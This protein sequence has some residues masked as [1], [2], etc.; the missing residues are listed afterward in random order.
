[1]IALAP[2]D[3]ERL[4]MRLL[5][6]LEGGRTA[7]AR[8]E[9]RELI[10][11]H[12]ILRRRAEDLMFY[13]APVMRLRRADALWAEGRAEE[14]LRACD[15]V[16]NDDPRSAAA[17]T[18]KG[19]CLMSLERIDAA[20]AALK[21]ASR[22]AP[23]TALPHKRLGYVLFSCVGDPAGACAAYERA[24]ALDPTDG[25]ALYG[26]AE[27]RLAQGDRA[28][29]FADLRAAAEDADWHEQAER[30]IRDAGPAA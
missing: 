7:E 26:R 10:R 18:V 13:G 23:R 20:C 24:L 2:A 5:F 28:G 22:L 16:L 14:A 25:E 15:E 12:P 8:S 21:E 27:V 30:L 3:P 1:M 29:A 11:M 6:L 9:E 19:F 17:L 4:L